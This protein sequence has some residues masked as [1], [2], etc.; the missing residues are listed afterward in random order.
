MKKRWAIAVPAGILVFGAFMY[1]TAVAIMG[2]FTPLRAALQGM[3]M[4]GVVA[5]EIILIAWAANESR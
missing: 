4:L 1:M 3:G 2:P 5:L